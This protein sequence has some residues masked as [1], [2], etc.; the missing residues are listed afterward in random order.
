MQRLINCKER[1]ENFYKE[2]A[3]FYDSLRKKLLHGRGDMFANISEPR[4]LHSKC[5]II[6]GVW[7]D[8]GGG[9]GSSIEIMAQQQKLHLFEKVY[10]VDLSPSLLEVAK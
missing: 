2:Q 7:V 9:T 3:E 5:L 6:E 4:G 1:L 8:M 10:V